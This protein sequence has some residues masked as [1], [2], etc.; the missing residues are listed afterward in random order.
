[1]VSRLNKKKMIQGYVS[2]L[3]KDKSTF[4]QIV[5][6]V[7]IKGR[8][9]LSYVALHGD[10]ET[11]QAIMTLN[12]DPNQCHINSIP[13][14]ESVESKNIEVVEILLK[15][16]AHVDTQDTDGNTALHKAAASSKH[17]IVK[18]LL[19]NKANCDIVNKKNQTPLHLAV[20]A[21]KK[22]TNRSFKSERLLLQA[23]ADINA[24]DLF[25]KYMLY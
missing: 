5:N 14:I 15:S 25:G 1:M 23:G 4:E 6:D 10:V 24:K 12:P 22:Q 8:S 11:L 17:A 20:D 2:C 9:A 16:G 21:T 3:S 18:L 19:E 13:L 7:N